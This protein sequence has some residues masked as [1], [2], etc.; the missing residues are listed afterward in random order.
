[1]SKNKTTK[2]LQDLQELIPSDSLEQLNEENNKREYQKKWVE[3]KYRFRKMISKKN[4]RWL[5]DNSNLEHFKDLE[6]R[7]EVYEL[8][9][10]MFDEEKKRNWLIHILTNFL[11]LNVAKQVPKLP[12]HKMYCPFTQL[13]LTDTDSILRGDRDKNLG[14]TGQNTDMIISAIAVKEIY[15]FA[16]DCTKNFD[17]KSGHIVNYAL[18]KER[19]KSNN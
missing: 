13:P 4:R 2:S 1:M 17:T 19:L 8:I 6:Y 12:K 16:I 18:D 11:P 10:T 3:N 9:S 5:I 15:R 14:Y 7:P